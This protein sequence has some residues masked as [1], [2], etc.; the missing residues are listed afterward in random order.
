MLS[1]IFSIFRMWS[2]IIRSGHGRYLQEVEVQHVVATRSDN[3]FRH[4]D[5]LEAKTQVYLIYI[6]YHNTMQYILKDLPLNISGLPQKQENHGAFDLSRMQTGPLQQ[7]TTLKSG[8][9]AWRKMLLKRKWEKAKWVIMGLSGGMLIL[10]MWVEVEDGVEDKAPH[11]YWKIF[12]VDL[13]HW[14]E[15]WSGN[16]RE[17]PSVDHDKRI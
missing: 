8:C 14:G 1:I 15:F 9:K 6:T 7:H 17:F 5:K 11:H 3:L 13:P 4:R 10:K 2:S 16:Q 12:L